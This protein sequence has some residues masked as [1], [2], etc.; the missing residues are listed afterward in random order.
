[1]RMGILF[2]APAGV[3]L[4]VLAVPLVATIFYH[5]AMT[6]MAVLMAAL[7]LQAFAV[8]T[9]GFVIAKIAAPGY[10][11]RHDTTTPF[12]IALASVGTNLVVSLSVFT[13]FGHVGLALATSTAAI[14]QSYLLVRGLVR[15]GVYRPEPGFG[16]FLVKV[17]VAVVVMVAV[18]VSLT[19]PDRDWLN[20][21]TLRRV[22]ELALICGAGFVAYVAALWLSGVRPDA[23]RHRV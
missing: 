11:A 21:S 4:Y 19:A 12:R 17:A 15:R 1:M 8:G 13:F 16:M 23:L 9:L 18:L 2:G 22:L 3:A 7:S 6:G 10:F 20:F 5:G 14:V